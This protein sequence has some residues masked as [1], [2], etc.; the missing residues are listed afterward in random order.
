MQ[1]LFACVILFQPLIPCRFCQSQEKKGDAEGVEKGAEKRRGKK[2]TS[3]LSSISDRSHRWQT[4]SVVRR[5]HKNAV[6][7]QQETIEK[8]EHRE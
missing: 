3:Q 4:K 2:E 6:L 5:C 8:M 7:N 1:V